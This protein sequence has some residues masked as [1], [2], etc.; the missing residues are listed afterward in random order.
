M[1]QDVSH[2]KSVVGLAQPVS[3]FSTRQI[4]EKGAVVLSRMLECYREMY[5][6]MSQ[7]ILD[8][9]HIP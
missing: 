4:K 3:E 9:D 1:P 6:E 2:Q 5:L 7:R 8:N